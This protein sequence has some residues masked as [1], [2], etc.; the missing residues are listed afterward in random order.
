MARGA[1][2]LANRI[3]SFFFGKGLVRFE[4]GVKGGEGIGLEIFP[5]PDERDE[6]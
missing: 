3:K 1:T 5:M 4:K 6:G 2:N